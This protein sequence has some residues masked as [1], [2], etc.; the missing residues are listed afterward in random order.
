MQDVVADRTL[1]VSNGGI[2]G[3]ATVRLGR[4]RQSGDDEW[5]CPVQILGLDDDEVRDVYGVDSLQ[6]LVLAL[7]M[8]RARVTTQPS[9]VQVTWM[10]MDDLG[11]G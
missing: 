5:A 8:V 2:L 9:G 1:E 10:G 11:L 7:Q 3:T 6:A 4:P